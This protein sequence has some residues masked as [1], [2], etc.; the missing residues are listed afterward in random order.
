LLLGG[1]LLS[2]GPGRWDVGRIGGRALLLLLFRE[3]L[4]DFRYAK[5]N[6]AIFFA[7]KAVRSLELSRAKRRYSSAL[8][9]ATATPS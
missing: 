8:E 2:S 1:W 4:P 6:L 5:Q 7:L 9:L 3:A